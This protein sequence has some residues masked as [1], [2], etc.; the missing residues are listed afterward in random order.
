MLVQKIK[1]QVRDVIL[2]LQHWVLVKVYHMDISPS[3]KISLGANL[4][5]ANPRGVHIGDET[6][7]ASGASI[8]THDGCR[9]L[10]ADTHIGRRCFIGAGSR[11]LPGVTLGDHTIV[12]VDAV[13]TRSYPIGGVILAGNPARVIR[14]HVRTK[15]Y[16][17]I[18]K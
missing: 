1:N 16:G 13:V 2:K 10:H 15:K 9:L 5:M 14:E 8:M 12:G 7:G 17:V 3:A 4:D 18:I 11:V 6:Y